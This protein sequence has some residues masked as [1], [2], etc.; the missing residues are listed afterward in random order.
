MQNKSDA[1]DD[2]SGQSAPLKPQASS[3]SDP[4][5]NP[6]E[7]SER[8]KR[9]ASDPNYPNPEIVKSMAQKLLDLFRSE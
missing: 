7:L 6:T 2:Q 3:P 8:L 5:V 1:L 4:P 9:L